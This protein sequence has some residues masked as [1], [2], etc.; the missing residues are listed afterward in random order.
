[1][2]DLAKRTGSNIPVER[3]GAIHPYV[4]HKKGSG[5]SH[6]Y[7]G[8]FM[9]TRPYMGVP[10]PGFLPNSRDFSTPKCIYPQI[11]ATYPQKFVWMWPIRKAKSPK[12]GHVFRKCI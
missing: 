1:M 3:F 5:T 4:F 2:L 11:I 8:N 10:G 7:F 12:Y 9:E 6:P